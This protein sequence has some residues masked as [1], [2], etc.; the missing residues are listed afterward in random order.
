MSTQKCD[1]IAEGYS[2]WGVP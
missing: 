1:S 2:K